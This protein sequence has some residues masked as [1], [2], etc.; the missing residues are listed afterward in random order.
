MVVGT[1]TDFPV[2]PFCGVAHND[3]LTGYENEYIIYLFYECGNAYDNLEQEW[4]DICCN[5]PE[6]VN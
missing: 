5:Q 3:M 1:M 2:C 6:H 4:I